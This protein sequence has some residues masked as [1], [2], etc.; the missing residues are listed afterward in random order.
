MIGYKPILSN[1][2]RQ[3]HLSANIYKLYQLV[4]MR[5]VVFF[6]VF[7]SDNASTSDTITRS[8]ATDPKKISDTDRASDPA[9]RVIKIIQGYILCIST[10]SPLFEFNFSSKKY[11]F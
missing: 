5:T 10:P 7:R 6:S 8:L 11:P 2:K 9:F 1:K 4:L 3:K